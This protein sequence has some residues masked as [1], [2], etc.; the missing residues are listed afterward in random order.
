MAI[1]LGAKP[2][3][4]SD[5]PGKSV[6]VPD[7][8]VMIAD[9]EVMV[10]DLEV[11]VTDREVMVNDRE[12]MVTDRAVLVADRAVLV[13]DSA[14]LVADRAVMVAD[15]AVMVADPGLRPLLLGPVE[16]GV[17]EGEVVPRLEDDEVG[18]RCDHHEEHDGRYEHG[19]TPGDFVRHV[20]ILSTFPIIGDTVGDSLGEDL[21][22]LE[23]RVEVI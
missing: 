21:V 20:G 3:R 22:A 17:I 6:I 4:P 18:G 19:L 5:A 10:A 2:L 23:R 1:S 16:A 7:R 15:R 12:V 13:A 8:E 11:M 14:V 9:R